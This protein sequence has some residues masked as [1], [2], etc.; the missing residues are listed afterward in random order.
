MRNVMIESMRPPLVRL[1]WQ[2]IAFLWFCYVLNQADRQ[3]VY[4]LF[5]A[6][7]KALGFSD[8]VLGLTGALFLWVYGAFSP[9]AGILG[10]RMSR[11]ALVVGSLL[12]WSLLTVLSGLAPNGA[13]LL[14]CRALLGVSESFFMPAG[15]GLI[16]AAHGPQTRSRAIAVFGTSQLVGVAIGGT[17]SAYIAQR[18][19]WRVSFL[20]LGGTGLL[21]ALPLSRFFRRISDDYSRAETRSTADLRSF[22]V[23]LKIPTVQIIAFA[24]A[25]AT[26]GLYLVYT[27]LPTFLY[28]KFQ[29]GL[30]RAGFEASVYPQLG[31]AGGLLVGGWLADRFH[32][33]V[34]AS[35]FWIILIALFGGAPCMFLLGWLG[36][37]DETRLAAIGVGFFAGFVAGNQAAA[38]FD[39]VPPNL[40]SSA[41]GVLNL[42][43]AFVSGFAP[44]LG[45]L[46][47]RTIG[48]DRLMAFT[49]ALYVLTG[50][51]LLYGILRHFANDRIED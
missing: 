9:I 10:D 18:F 24:I 42:V 30:A 36:K 27:W 32:S 31:T 46:A 28:D 17:V 20:L 12:L 11:T 48:V 15:Y 14:G 33:R 49:A 21:F 34:A 45:G 5:P 41:I 23:L 47:R 51:I 29:I 40:R 26:F 22:L 16:A 19:D 8:A 43:G 37:L 35:R 39:V 2:L 44:F 50:L 25:V 3:V 13:F 38:T 7:Q 4:T 6:L 1:E